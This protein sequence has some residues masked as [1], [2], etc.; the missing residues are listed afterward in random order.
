[1]VIGRPLTPTRC[2][3]GKPEV[4][5]QKQDANPFAAETFQVSDVGGE[6]VVTSIEARL[7]SRREKRLD[8]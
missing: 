3:L 1:M 6:S 4:V 2:V 5:D 8:L 7:E